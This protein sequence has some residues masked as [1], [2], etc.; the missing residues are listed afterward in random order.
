[1]CGVTKAAAVLFSDGVVIFLIVAQATPRYS[2]TPRSR[3]HVN[4]NVV[5]VKLGTLAEGADHLQT[6]D[7]VFCSDF[8]C[9][10]VFSSVSKLRYVQ[11]SVSFGWEIEN[12]TR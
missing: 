11:E 3:Q 10:C 9:R 5:S 2:A 1:M 12:S 4:T 7:P 8:G 6:G